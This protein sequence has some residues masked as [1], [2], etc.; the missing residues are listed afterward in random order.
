[1]NAVTISPKFQ[2]VIPLEVRERMRLEPGQKVQ[3]M[4][5]DDR[6]QLVPVRRA[7]DLRGFLRGI[8]TRVERDP[9]RE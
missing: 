2:I 3:V 9:D 4:A 6:I 1:V 5:F 7:K 8:D